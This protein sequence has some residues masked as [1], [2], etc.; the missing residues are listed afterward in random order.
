MFERGKGIIKKKQPF[1]IGAIDYGYAKLA[2]RGTAL[3]TMN[4]IDRINRI[5]S[6]YNVESVSSSRWSTPRSLCIPFQTYRES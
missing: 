6:I 3:V 5:T 1:E 2:R 4:A